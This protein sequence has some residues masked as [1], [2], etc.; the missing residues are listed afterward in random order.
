MKRF[1][2]AQQAYKNA[3]SID[4]FCWQANRRLK[5]LAEETGKPYRERPDPALSATENK[6][7][8]HIRMAEFYDAIKIIQHELSIRPTPRLYTFAGIIFGKT[9]DYRAALK[10]FDAALKLDPDDK[11]AL[12]NLSV[13]YYNMNQLEKAYEVRKRLEQLK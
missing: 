9:G 8:S 4:Y 3:L 10:A 11:M 5:L 1:S 2:E 12:H 7:V 13:L 6:I